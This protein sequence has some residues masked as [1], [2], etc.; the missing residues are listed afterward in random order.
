MSKGKNTRQTQS[1][2]P[3]VVNWLDCLDAQARTFAPL[4]DWTSSYCQKLCMEPSGG[5]LILPDS[6][7]KFHVFNDLSQPAVTL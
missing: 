7:D 2:N 1:A 5:D 4:Q 3:E 6:V